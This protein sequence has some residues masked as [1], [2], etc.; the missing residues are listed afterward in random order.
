M[1]RRLARRRRRGG[2]LGG[3]AAFLRLAGRADVLLENF[4]PGAME[5]LG[6]GYEALRERF[7][8][9]IYCAISGFGA[10]GPLREKA[11]LDLIM[12]GYGGLMAI[13]GEADGPP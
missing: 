4:R 2:G 7:P 9:L 8:R 12:Q 5:R 1:R 11:G 3:A 10:S 6:L 13:T